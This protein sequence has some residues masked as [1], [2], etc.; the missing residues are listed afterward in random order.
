MAIVELAH[1]LRQPAHDVLARPDVEPEQPW[2]RAVAAALEDLVA[3]IRYRLYDAEAIISKTATAAILTIAIGGTFAAVMEGIITGIQFVYPESETSQTIAAMG[4]AVVAA[5]FIEPINRRTHDWVERRFHKALLEIRENLPELMRDTRDSATLDEFLESVLSRLVTVVLSVRGAVILDDEVKETVG[6]TKAEVMQWKENYNPQFDRNVLD[7]VPA[8]HMFPLRL[9]VETTAESFG[10]LLIG[11]RPDGSIPGE[12][13]QEALEKIAGTL[14]RSIR[15]VL[16][17]DEE[18]QQMLRLIQ[19]Q[20]E[21]IAR[22]EKAL[23]L[24]S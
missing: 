15:I 1:A 18:K 7:C 8:D 9:E 10:W 17:R 6:A 4:G 24:Q 16:S 14:G 21:R 20:G 19:D 5:V 3:L 12:D 22:I 11:P 2:M 23:K 13:E